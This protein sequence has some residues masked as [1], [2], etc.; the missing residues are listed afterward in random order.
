M[1]FKVFIILVFFALT[2][3]TAKADQLAL[4]TLDEAK[5]AAD[6]ISQQRELVLWCACCEYETKERVSVTS[7]YYRLAGDDLYETVLKYKDYE[8]NLQERTIDLA[9]VHIFINGQAHCLGQIL[10]MRCDPCTAP[11]EW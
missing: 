2:G 1:N 11:F 5:K 8:G 9:Y 7:V 6:Y 3:A 4:I 10:E